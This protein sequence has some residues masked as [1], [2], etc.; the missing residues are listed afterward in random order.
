MRLSVKL[1]DLLLLVITQLARTTVDQ[2]QETANDGE[3][4]EEIV[5]GKVLVW[6]VFM[7]LWE[8]RSACGPK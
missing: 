2:E 1:V 8:Y 4:L 5:F 3:N 6:V 7:E